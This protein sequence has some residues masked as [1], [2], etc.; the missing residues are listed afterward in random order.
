[1]IKFVDNFGTILS[2]F[3][4]LHMDIFVES[5]DY[6]KAYK[7]RFLRSRNPTRELTT[8]FSDSYNIVSSIVPQ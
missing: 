7:M 2:V 8:Y 5:R 3:I 4:L 6:S 1:M